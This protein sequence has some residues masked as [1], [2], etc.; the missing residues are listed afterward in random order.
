MGL[1]RARSDSLTDLHTNAPLILL[2]E[3][4][5]N[6]ST[7]TARSPASN[8]KFHLF[9]GSPFSKNSPCSLKVLERGKKNQFASN[10]GLATRT[11]FR[12]LNV[13]PLR[14]GGMKLNRLTRANSFHFYGTRLL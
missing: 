5:S 3:R 14:T 6:E 10:F 7:H 1:I 2:R 12:V 11:G 8:S 4:V 9:L 13:D